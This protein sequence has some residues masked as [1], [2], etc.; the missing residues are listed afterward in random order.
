M[1][2]MQLE[3]WCNRKEYEDLA[4]EYPR[5]ELGRILAQEKDLYRLA[6][7]RGEGFARV[8]GKFRYEVNAISE[9]P[10]VGDFVLVEGKAGGET[11]VIQKLLPRKSVFIRKAAGI[12]PEEQVVAANIDTVFLCMSLNRDFNIRRLERYLSI[13]WDSGAVPVVVLTKADLCEDLEAKELE[14]EETAMGVSIVHT[15]GMTEEGIR[16]LYPYLK[17]GK[18]VAFLGSSGVGKSTII[19]RLLGEERLQTGALREDDKGRHT[20]TRRELFY[21]PGKGLVIDTPGM[22]QLGMWNAEKGIDRTFADIEA[23]A[24]QCRFRDCTHTAEPGCAVQRAVKDGVISAERLKAYR[25]LKAENAYTEDYENYLTEKKKK[26]KEIAR[27]NKNN[28]KK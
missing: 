6:T 11:V 17:E 22:R 10:A 25:K 18:T 15:S 9:F 19:N 14:V 21:I 2:K 16:S 28:L 23:L 1:E 20:T 4:A 12:H 24:E 13:A 7:E 26:F 8:S 27:Y 5:Y 3:K